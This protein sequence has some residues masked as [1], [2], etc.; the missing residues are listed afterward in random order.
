MRTEVAGELRVRSASWWLSTGALLTWWLGAGIALLTGLGVPPVQRT[1]EARVL[2]TAREMLGSGWHGWM[3]PMLDG[4]LRV[5]K[6][7]LTYW[8]AAAAY[9]VGGI[10]ERTGRT[11]TALLGWLTLAVTFACGQWLFGRQAGFFAA[12]CL[13]CSYLF[14]RYTRLAETDAPA[15]FFV[16]LG[17]YAFWRGASE[18]V[19]EAV[20]ADFPNNLFLRENA[21]IAEDQLHSNAPSLPSPLWWHLGAG[22]TAL[23][24]MSKGPPG[25]YPPL[26]L[27]VLAAMQRRWEVLGRFVRS[28]AVLTLLILAAPWFIYILH[29][30]GLEQ[31]KRESDELLG[32]EDHGG[33]FYQYFIELFKATAPW[34]VAMPGAL[35]AALRFRRDPRI[36]GLLVWLGVVFVPL[37]FVGNKQFHYLM[38][39]MPPMMIAIGWWIDLALGPANVSDEG[40]RVPLLDATMLLT[41]LAVP[42]APLAARLSFG[43]VASLDWMLAAIIA[44]GLLV[45]GWAYGQ[46]GRRMALLTYMAAVLIVLVP[47]VS[48]LAPRYEGDD[49]RSLARGFAG[50]FGSGPYCFYGRNFSLPLCFNLRLQIPQVMTPVELRRLADAE[51][52]LVVIA[53]TKSK[54]VPP[55]IPPGFAQEKPDIEVPRQTFRL[56]R[57]AS[58]SQ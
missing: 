25:V 37:C 24:I 4:Q 54:F 3:T 17:I 10:S 20:P 43:K 5:R 53:Q 11:P 58:S 42:A 46:H 52:G 36:A 14:F 41:I 1:Q 55:P 21:E 31:W 56:Y 7:P 38:P 9:E 35:I 34:C 29:A 2:E 33:H 13:L 8:M 47:A 15:M 57:A 30:V 48:I 32:G 12:A 16:T 27:I 40:R 23:A 22:A 19:P 51:P 18:G 50:R 26:F 39:L 49:S 45:V 6:P 44:L 28:G